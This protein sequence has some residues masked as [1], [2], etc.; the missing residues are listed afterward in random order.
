MDW[1]KEHR[2]V[3]ITIA[4]AILL[5]GLTAYIKG[6]FVADSM[7]KVMSAMSDVCFVPGVL[8]LG[9][10]LI[11]WVTNNGFFDGVKY[12]FKNMKRLGSQKQYE[13]N[14]ESF[15]DYKERMSKAKLPCGFLLIIG[16]ALCILAIFFAIF[17]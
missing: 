16:G 4:V 14:M 15:L 12:S 6:L 1:I 13:E 11:I 5:G 8:I 17:A 2:A 7:Q 9:V 10:G 3:I